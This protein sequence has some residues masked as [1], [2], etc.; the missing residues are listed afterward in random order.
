M[1]LNF[2]T[3]NGIPIQGARNGRSDREP[4]E[5]TPE[6]AYVRSKVTL[7]KRQRLENRLEGTKDSMK[8]A[9]IERRLAKC[10]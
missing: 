10:P 1:T 7:S 6:M 3:K 8:R 9:R 2:L 5:E 4:D